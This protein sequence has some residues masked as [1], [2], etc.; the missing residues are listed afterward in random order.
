MME[1]DGKESGELKRTGGGGRVRVFAFLWGG[2]L[3]EGYSWRGTGAD[4][5]GVVSPLKWMEKL[6]EERVAI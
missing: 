5:E 6:E 1:V 2:I 3:D 4:F